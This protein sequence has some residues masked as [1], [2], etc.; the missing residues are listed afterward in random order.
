M[1]EQEIIKHVEAAIAVSR[2][3][4]K[5]WQHK[6]MEILLEVG[7]IVFA[8]SLSIW[9][10]NWSESLKDR[11]EARQFLIGLKEDLRGDSAEMEGDL[12][13]YRM[14]LRGMRYFARVGNGEAPVT[15]SMRAYSNVLFS[16]V[17]FDPRIS[18]F[19]ALKGS[20]KLNII[21]NKDL[22]LHV[23]D[24]YTK[25]FPLIT[26]RNDWANAARQNFT[27]PYVMQ[28]LQ[29]DKSGRGT[30]WL[31]ILQSTPIRFW[32]QSESVTNNIEAY[33]DGVRSVGVLLKEI[34]DALK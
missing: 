14:E 4:T 11:S 10:H 25:V 30:N 17:H 8:V 18:R 21:E 1:A 3:R 2:D 22:L 23:T 29:M 27:T 19:E 6:L 31:E 26:R 15:D 7:I 9:F 20:G 13:T 5:K 28:H 32:M 12:A 34:D 16:F 24:L 33:A